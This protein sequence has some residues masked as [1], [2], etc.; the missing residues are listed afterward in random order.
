[1]KR[2]RL[3]VVASVLI[4]LAVLAAACGGTP[5]AAVANLPTTTTALPNGTAAN[6]GT[7]PDRDF[8]RYATCMRSHGVLHF[9]DDPASPAIRALKQSGAMSSPQFQA[10]ARACVKYLPPHTSPPRITPQDQA[11]YLKAAKC[12]RDHGIAGFPDPVFSEGNVNFPIPNGMNT[13]SAQFRRAREI[14]QMLVRPGLPYSKG[15]ESG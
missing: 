2:R 10:A 14:C 9:P 13:K 15:A 5:K 11:G 6:A 1:M 8:V 12:M 3:L 7:S 4:G